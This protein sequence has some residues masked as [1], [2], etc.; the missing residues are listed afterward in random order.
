MKK[1]YNLILLPTL[2]LL[3]ISSYSHDGIKKGYHFTENKGQINSK[4]LFHSVLNIG[5]M[6]LEKDRF[7]FDLFSADEMNNK[8]LNNKNKKISFENP[9][10]NSSKKINRPN[11]FSPSSF[12]K[13][14]Y[15]MIFYGSNPNVNITDR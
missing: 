15:S 13:H 9:Q 6:F 8:I 14:S 4:V 3:T 12:S 10:N 2:I 5:N 1:I 7:T 11:N